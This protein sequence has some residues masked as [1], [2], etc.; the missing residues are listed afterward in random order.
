VVEESR[1]SYGDD[2]IASVG[3]PWGKMSVAAL[4][5]IVVIGAAL[6]AFAP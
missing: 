5:V 1:K 6:V 4:V 3:I 2:Y